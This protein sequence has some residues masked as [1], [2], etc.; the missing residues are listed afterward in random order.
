MD[1]IKAV[2]M[3]NTLKSIDER[4][5]QLVE[6]NKEAIELNRK[7]CQINE[8]MYNIFIK[9]HDCDEQALINK[10]KL[11]RTVNRQIN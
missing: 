3:L 10:N 11:I 9:K 6:L 7:T 1:N 2:T 8:T 5:G 4:L